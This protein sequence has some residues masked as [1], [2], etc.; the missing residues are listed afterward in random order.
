MDIGNSTSIGYL[1]CSECGVALSSHQRACHV[2]DPGDSVV[3]QV[4]KARVQLAAVEAEL[5]RFLE[6]PAGRFASFLAERQ[7]A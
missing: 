3:H 7:R 5:A 4:T 1:P 2:C 6:T